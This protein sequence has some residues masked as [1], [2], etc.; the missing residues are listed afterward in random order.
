MECL[1]YLHENGCPWNEATFS[2]AAAENGE[3]E[4]LN[5]SMPMAVHRMKTFRESLKLVGSLMRRGG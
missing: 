1:K 3:L 5:T 2:R 4:M